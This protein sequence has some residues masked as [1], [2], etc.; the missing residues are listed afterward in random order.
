VTQAT[1]A[2]SGSATFCEGGSVVLTASADGSS[3]V[4]STTETTRSITVTNSGNYS[5]TIF[6]NNGC[7][8]NATQA[9]TVLSL[10]AVTVNSSAICAGDSAILTASTTADNPSYLWNPGGATTASI[11]V[12]PTATT[13][14]T[15]TVTD[16]TTT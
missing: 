7:S 6:D 8:A 4:W 13:T 9:V 10:P 11:T 15:V 12:S 3:Y 2:T 5:V 14:Y 1:I 16:G